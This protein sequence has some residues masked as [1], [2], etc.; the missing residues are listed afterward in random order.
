M[1][2]PADISEVSGPIQ[3][4]RAFGQVYRCAS[5]QQES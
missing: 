3:N 1:F 4:R 2:E 5:L